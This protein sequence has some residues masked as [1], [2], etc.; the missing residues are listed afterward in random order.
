MARQVTM[1]KSCTFTGHRPK[2]MFGYNIQAYAGLSKQ[3]YACIEQLYKLGYRQFITGG[4]QGFDQLVFWAVAQ[5]KQSHPEIQNVVYI[6]HP[7]QEAKWP[8]DGLF[9]QQQ[10]QQMLN[11]ADQVVTVSNQQSI[12]SL[13]QRNEA[14]VDAS[15]GIV[16]LYE[17]DSWRNPSTKSGTASTMRYAIKHMMDIW[18]I[19]FD[20]KSSG[21][22]PIKTIQKSIFL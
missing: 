1:L 18:Q 15:D 8:V 14:M 22:Y 2:A 19:Q 16:C 21:P 10:Y 20:N 6:P 17:D 5:F 12:Q 13:F 3:L 11:I 4:A 9:G 7:G